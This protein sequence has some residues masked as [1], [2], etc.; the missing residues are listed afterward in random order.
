LFDFIQFGTQKLQLFLLV[1][2]RTSGL[3]LLAPI[4]SHRSIPNLA[5][6]GLVIMLSLI[7]VAVLDA[8]S[9]PAVSSLAELA[10]VAF[11]ELFVGATIGFV[12]MLV[13]WAVQ[14]A[15]SVAGYQIGMYIANALDPTTQT[16]SSII[17][18]VWFLLGLLVFLSI[19]GHHLVISAFADSYRVIPPGM[20]FWEG[21]VGEMVLRYTAYVFVIA[22]KVVSPVMV[23]L[24][25]T[26]VALGTLAKLMPTM[27][28]F[29]VGFPVKIGIGLVVLAISLPV[30]S[31]VLEKSM[32]YLDRELHL[33][34]LA[35][36]K[37]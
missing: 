10:G 3:F 25:L 29:F 30:F 17:G 22:L 26:D 14:G 21:S 35:M 36:G 13:F 9:V 2:L 15:G 18:Q 33:L 7:L 32:G 24:F 4:L 27:N 28:V 12:F 6:A 5:K 20:V 16:Q 8:A 34:F 19:N 23:T 37:A 11:K 1:L 31:F